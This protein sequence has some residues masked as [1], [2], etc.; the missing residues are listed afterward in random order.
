MADHRLDHRSTQGG[1]R[2]S[3]ARRRMNQS[4]FR[5]TPGTPSFSL[6]SRNL[7]PTV[8]GNPLFDATFSDSP[9]L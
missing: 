7:S 6:K 4:A 9:M 5:G 3:A 2:F 8:R 1:E